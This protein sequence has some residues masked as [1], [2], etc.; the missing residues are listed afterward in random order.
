M[1]STGPPPF[2]RQ[3]HRDSQPTRAWRSHSI[4]TV[5]CPCKTSRLARHDSAPAVDSNEAL[6]EDAPDGPLSLSP[7]SMVIR[8]WGPDLI[9]NFGRRASRASA[10][11]DGSFRSERCVRIVQTFG[12][13]RRPKSTARRLESVGRSVESVRGRDQRPQRCA[14][15]EA[16]RTEGRTSY[17]RVKRRVATR[18]RSP[19]A[20]S[21]T[22]PSRR[23]PHSGR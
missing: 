16:L 17:D 5:R 9:M 2:P 15:G 12:T 11:C 13:E 8:R 18:L 7:V 19:P 22:F 14:G 6:T 10:P 23:A 20:N 4:S 1:H 21:S 3:S